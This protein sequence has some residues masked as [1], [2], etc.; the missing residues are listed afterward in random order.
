V[1]EL[2]VPIVTFLCLVGAAFAGAAVHVGLPSRHFTEDTMATVRTALNIFVVITSV[3]LALMLNSAKSTFDANHTN[4]NALATEIVLLD[5]TMRTLGLQAD[6]ARGRLVEYVRR[7]V[8]EANVSELD[9]Q[10]EASLDAVGASLRAIK[11]TG[12]QKLA[13]WNDAY[14]VYRQVVRER[15]IGAAGG[16]IPAPLLA[17]LIMWQTVIFAGL[18]FRAPR[19]P[20]VTTTFFITALLLS[21]ALY[22][23]LEMDRPASGLIRISNAPFERA[24]AELQR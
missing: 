21:S 1:T 23:I 5:R 8:G 7:V 6:E 4:A 19:N 2:L 18:G 9:P 10:A 13:M 20:I 24:L 11:V 22:L 17:A 15:W 16:T 14:E 12:D 3:V